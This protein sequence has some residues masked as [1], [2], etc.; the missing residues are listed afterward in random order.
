MTPRNHRNRIVAFL[1]STGNVKVGLVA[2]DE[3]DAACLATF[4]FN[5]SLLNSKND[6][7]GLHLRGLIW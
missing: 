6:E 3:A 2:S 7:I 1:A 4:F 5:A